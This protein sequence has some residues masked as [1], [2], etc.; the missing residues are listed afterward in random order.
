MRKWQT[1][2]NTIIE[3][4]T[5][6]GAISSEREKLSQTDSYYDDIWNLAEMA[7]GIHLQIIK[8]AETMTTQEELDYITAEQSRAEEI[9]S[10]EL[11]IMTTTDTTG[12][13]EAVREM[14]YCEKCNCLH[15]VR[16]VFVSASGDRV[17]DVISDSPCATDK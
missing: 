14:R 15:V 10:P 1:P 11:V 9:R 5:L 6:S 7:D 16:T 12:M 8:G 17:V 3:G 4:I 13:I 2:S